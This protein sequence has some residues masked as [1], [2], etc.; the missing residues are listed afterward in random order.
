A[1]LK[2]APPSA[3]LNAVISLRTH[4]ISVRRNNDRLVA[5]SICNS[6]RRGCAPIGVGSPA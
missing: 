5:P 6:S 2:A 1:R 3:P 4:R